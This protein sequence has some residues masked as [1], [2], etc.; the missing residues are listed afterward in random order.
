VALFVS[1]AAVGAVFARW[2]NLDLAVSHIFYDHGGF[3]G[4]SVGQ[5]FARDVFRD[6]PFVVLAFFVT[7]YL[8]RRLGARAETGSGRAARFG[9]LAAFLGRGA[10]RP[11][12]NPAAASWAP[13]GRAIVF[14]VASLVI[15]SG[16]VVNLGMKDH[17]HRPRPVQTREFGGR[18]EFRPW[19]RFDGGC[20]KNCG[21]PSGE[22][23]SSF[24]MVAP[25][26]L[27]PPPFQSVAI[28]GALA[29]GVAASVLRLA[30]GGH[31]LSDVL[32]GGLISL[33]VVFGV[34]RLVWPRGAP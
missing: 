16:L 29:F 26:L 24:W 6:G 14:L 18:D 3:L 17:L 30:F 25:A 28:A 31:Y 5:R 27:V 2:P 13:D 15:G 4:A 7:V 19:Y 20:D 9:P 11:R 33:I 1:L 34:R 21:F 23:S 8:Q 32:M 22:A 12:P 10:A